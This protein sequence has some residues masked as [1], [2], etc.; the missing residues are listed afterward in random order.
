MKTDHGQ[1][2]SRRTLVHHSSATWPWQLCET[3]KTKR[4]GR[5]QCLEH[6]GY[7]PCYLRTQAFLVRSIFL[8]LFFIFYN[9]Y[10]WS[11]WIAYFDRKWGHYFASWWQFSRWVSFWVK[12]SQPPHISMCRFRGLRSYGAMK[13]MP[14]S[15]TNRGSA[16]LHQYDGKIGVYFVTINFILPVTGSNHIFLIL[17]VTDKAL[18][19][20]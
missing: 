4:T 7:K 20:C 12:E 13:A 18:F 14:S 3:I 10:F 8:T 19:T 11:K 1:I 6:S 16:Q 2:Y 5:K 15:P 9:R 17:T